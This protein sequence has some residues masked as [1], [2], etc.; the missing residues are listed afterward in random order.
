MD[1]HTFLNPS[2]ENELSLAQQRSK[3]ELLREEMASNN[4]RIYGNYCTGL[5]PCMA[6]KFKYSLPIYCLKSV[7]QISLLREKKPSKYFLDKHN[8]L[9]VI[10]TAGFQVVDNIF[11]SL[12][13]GNA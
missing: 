13:F 4:P 12:F 11:Q 7:H 5:L 1:R 10:F 6:K 9:A 2:D 8:N 3:K